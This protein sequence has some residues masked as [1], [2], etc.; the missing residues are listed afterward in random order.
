M[1]IVARITISLRVVTL[2]LGSRSAVR[3]DHVI[4]YFVIIS[5]GMIP[6]L[7]LI[8]KFGLWKSMSTEWIITWV[9]FV[10]RLVSIKQGNVLSRCIVLRNCFCSD[11]RRWNIAA[12]SSLTFGTGIDSWCIFVSIGN[13]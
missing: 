9:F 5:E 2:P 8:A 11:D 10:H 1:A 12:V 13:V 7:E 6:R 3:Y 4:S